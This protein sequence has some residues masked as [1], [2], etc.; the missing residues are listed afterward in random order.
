MLMAELGRVRFKFWR[1]GGQG[2]VAT[3]QVTVASIYDTGA[4]SEN[5]EI[6]LWLLFEHDLIREKD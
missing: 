3:T 6:E 4:L 2:H 1:V 5:I